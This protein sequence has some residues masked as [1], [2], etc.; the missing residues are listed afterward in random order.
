MCDE[1]IVV[2]DGAKHVMAPEFGI[3]GCFNQMMEYS[4]LQ[5]LSLVLMSLKSML[6][7]H[8]YISYYLS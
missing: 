8:E 2:F 3:L 7:R 4:P 6:A 1:I 5:C